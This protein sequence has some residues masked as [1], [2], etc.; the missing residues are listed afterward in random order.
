MGKRNRLP[1]PKLQWTY[2]LVKL[3]QQ[4]EKFQNLVAA[5]KIVNHDNVQ[6]EYFTEIHNPTPNILYFCKPQTIFGLHV[7]D[8]RIHEVDIGDTKRGGFDDMQPIEKSNL[9]TDP[10]G[11]FLI[12]HNTKWH[13]TESFWDVA[14]RSYCAVNVL[15][16]QQCI[17]HPVPKSK[18]QITHINTSLPG[19]KANPCSEINFPH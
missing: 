4:L 9:Y 15:L 10:S 14:I 11:R 13:Q 1:F 17:R 16:L 3:I 18:L 19:I 2:I 5:Q 8:N 6:Q 12:V 7:R